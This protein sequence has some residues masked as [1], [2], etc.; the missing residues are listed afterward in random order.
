M[1][2]LE[3][4]KNEMNLSGKNVYVGHRYAPKMFGE[5]NNENIY[6]PLSIVQYQGASY[7][8]RQYVPVGVEITNEDYWALTGNYN[9]QIE[10]YRQDVRKYGEEVANQKLL[11][12]EYHDEVVQ[13]RTDKDNVTHD[14][15]KERLLKVDDDIDEVGTQF[16]DLKYRD[17]ASQNVDGAITNLVN[18][19]LT[20]A[21]RNDLQYGNDYTTLSDS[22]SQNANGFWEQDCSSFLLTIFNGTTFEESRYFKTE[23]R[24]GFWHYPFPVYD[25]ERNGRMLANGMAKWAYERGYTFEAN[26]E[27]TNL[28]PGDIYFD[29]SANPDKNFYENIGHVGIYLGKDGYTGK[30]FVFECGIERN[31]R[32]N[33]NPI[34]IHF[35]RTYEMQETRKTRM[36]ARLPIGNVETDTRCISNFN[37]KGGRTI[38]T[39]ENLKPNKVYTLFLKVDGYDFNNTNYPIVRIGERNIYSFNSLT[40]KPINGWIKAVFSLEDEDFTPDEVIKTITINN[41]GYKDSNTIL[42]FGLYDG[43]VSDVPN[44]PENLPTSYTKYYESTITVQPSEYGTIDFTGRINSDYD[45]KNYTRSSTVDLKSE[46]YSSDY[47]IPWVKG[48]A[49]NVVRLYNPSTV[50]RTVKV[51]LTVTYVKK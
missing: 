21:A 8:S 36:V 13:S 37:L 14:N 46:D 33:E 43:F 17:R 47:V 39:S 41:V 5:W 10:Q 9:A 34:G 22:V 2:D 32:K 29:H 19:G 31:P 28:I 18:I 30:H 4:F 44:I 23:N 24:T 40:I 27:F 15:L 35:R 20:Y 38:T 12:S 42:A 1:Q 6:E 16:N 45:I 3:Q 49:E 48:T 11:V 51:G 26:D 50:E 7:T 25:P